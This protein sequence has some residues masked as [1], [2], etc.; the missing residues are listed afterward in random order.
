LQESQ[1]IDVRSPGE[2]ERGHIPGAHNIPLFSNEERAVVGTLY[3]QKGRDEALLEGLRFVGPR[4]AELVERSRALA[5]AGH[6]RVHCWR[7]G[8]RSASVAWLLEKSGF[9]KVFTL[10]RGYKAF[11]QEVL[12]SFTGTRELRILGGY[13]GTGKTQLLHLLKERGEQVI[14]LEALANHKGSSYGGIGEGLQ[15]TTEHF[16][17]LLWNELRKID[18]S[19]TLWLEDESIEIGRAKLPA[20]LFATMR[21]APVHFIDMPSAYR[22]ERLV[23]IYGAFPK[24]E[25]AEATVRIER[26]LGP[27]H[28]KRAL[29]ALEQDDLHTVA[30]IALNYYDKA[31]A[32]G[33]A[34]REPSRTQ[35]LKVETNDLNEIA[36]LL[37]RQEHAR[38]D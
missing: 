21:S 38:H 35:P 5:P 25:L 1:V 3:K 20:P 13:T 18:P 19:R 26:R 29:E 6:V 23:E 11:R 17:N 33:L 34:M 9:K 30:A 27:Q 32:R 22:V 10:Q 7:G 2:F 4:M 31:Y 24:K 36:T 37:L 8:E 15:P 28:A 12:A 14:D 16:E